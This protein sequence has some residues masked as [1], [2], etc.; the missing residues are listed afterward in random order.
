MT[1]FVQQFF[2]GKVRSCK[3]GLALLSYTLR[4]LFFQINLCVI[5]TLSQRLGVDG[6]YQ[7]AFAYQKVHSRF[8]I[9]ANRA[10]IRD[11]YI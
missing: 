5:P 11:E 4:Y 8:D 6:V 9:Y 2:T 7:R 10:I 3:E 1:N